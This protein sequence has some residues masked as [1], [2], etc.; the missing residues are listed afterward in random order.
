M[1]RWIEVLKDDNNDKAA[2]IKELERTV[3]IMKNQSLES[4][5]PKPSDQR[6]HECNR[7]FE[8]IQK[9][10]EDP[11]IKTHAEVSLSL[12]EQWNICT[13]ER[14]QRYEQFQMGQ[15][16]VEQQSKNENN[17]K[18][19]KKQHNSK[20][21]GNNGKVQ[22]KSEK[23]SHE[24]QRKEFSKTEHTAKSHTSDSDTNSEETNKK[25]THNGEQGQCLLQANG[26]EEA[27]LQTRHN[28]KVRPFSGAT[29]EDMRSYL[30]PLLKRSLPLL[31]STLVQMMLQ[32][33]EWIL[34]YLFQGF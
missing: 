4:T 34:T 29:T 15:K 11:D 10:P 5:A 19:K 28:V 16:A 22:N 1:K 27:K 6:S 26:I 14:R 9:P 13:V 8:T 32:K 17:A 31:F 18:K 20:H 7:Q 25:S 23:S 2:R 3:E 30:L 21:K 24:S 33:M 12:E